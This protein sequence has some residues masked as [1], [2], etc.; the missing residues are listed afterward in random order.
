MRVK[1][2][3]YVLPY[4]NIAIEC[5][6]GYLPLANLKEICRYKMGVSCALIPS[7]LQVL[8]LNLQ[9]NVLS[10]PHLQNLILSLTQ[11]PH[12]RHDPLNPVRL[13]TGHDKDESTRI[14]AHGWILY[15][16]YTCKLVYIFIFVNLW[17]IM[18]LACETTHIFFQ[19]RLLNFDILL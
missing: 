12:V 16:A 1:D 14:C 9:I 4:E 7:V 13:P 6:S 2:R 18:I 5:H 3:T 19:N 11:W 15:F 10:I 8:L 17:L